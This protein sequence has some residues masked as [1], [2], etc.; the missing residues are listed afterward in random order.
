MQPSSAK[1]KNSDLQARTRKSKA[2]QIILALISL[3]YNDSEPGEPVAVFLGSQE[4]LRDLE[5]VLE[6]FKEL[7]PNIW[8]GG[9]S[10]ELRKVG[11]A[12]R[13]STHMLPVRFRVDVTSFPLSGVSLGG[14]RRVKYHR[15]FQSISSTS[16]VLFDESSRALL[17]RSIR[18]VDCGDPENET[19]VQSATRFLTP[20][21][22]ISLPP[23]LLSQLSQPCDT[24]SSTSYS[25]SHPQSE[26]SGNPTLL[27][28]HLRPPQPQPPS[29]PVLTV[30]NSP[31]Q[32]LSPH[33]PE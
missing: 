21:F 20:Q 10:S 5:V 14:R 25:S 13:W 32:T 24:E 9:D 18:S 30:A 16:D 33:R 22:H 15:V 11:D 7:E 17:Y 28:P 4:S 29:P 8:I 23:Q 6:I 1:M 26:Q 31:H 3:T 12:C 27:H 19:Q 2:K